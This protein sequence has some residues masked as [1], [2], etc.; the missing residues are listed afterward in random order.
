[1]DTDS[2][3]RSVESTQR[4]LNTQ[5][6]DEGHGVRIKQYSKKGGMVFGV[7]GSN[8]GE[9]DGGSTLTNSS[10]I[11]SPGSSEQG[12]PARD[13]RRPR[14][15]SEPRRSRG[16][17][18]Y[19]PGGLDGRSRVE[20]RNRSGG[21]GRK[22]RDDTGPREK[23]SSP[24]SDYGSLVSD[25]ENGDALVLKTAWESTLHKARDSLLQTSGNPRESL[26]V[27]T[28]TNRRQRQRSA[29]ESIS[30]RLSDAQ[31]Q[32]DKDLE[33]LW[34][35]SNS[36]DR[37]TSQYGNNAV[38]VRG[39]RLQQ[40]GAFNIGCQINTAESQNVPVEPATGMNSSK[41]SL[42]F[43]D[44]IAIAKTGSKVNDKN[45]LRNKLAIGATGV[46][47]EDSGC[48]GCERERR[49]AM[50]STHP[51]PS[52]S[53]SVLPPASRTE[54]SHHH[55]QKH[56]NNTSHAAQAPQSKPQ[57]KQPKQLLPKSASFVLPHRPSLTLS[58]PPG[59]SSLQP[60]RS[61]SPC[62]TD[63]RVK[64]LQENNSST[65]RSPANP[66]QHQ[67]HLGK[68]TLQLNSSSS[69]EAL[70]RADNNSSASH[71]KPTACTITKGLAQSHLQFKNN[72]NSK[73]QEFLSLLSSASSVTSSGCHGDGSVAGWSGG[74]GGCH[75]G[76]SCCL[77]VVQDVLSRIPPVVPSL[78]AG[79]R[80][81]SVLDLSWCSRS[82]SA[83]GSL[84]S[85]SAEY[86]PLLCG[87]AARYAAAT[88]APS[89]QLHPHYATMRLK[90]S[91]TLMGNAPC[92]KQRHQRDVDNN[93]NNAIKAKHVSCLLHFSPTAFL[94]T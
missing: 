37:N 70:T 48:R 94:T 44:K 66:A 24:S 20:P 56:N 50:N 49:Q 41:D 72:N 33:D 19:N 91:A 76:S 11:S 83:G 79:S 64:L 18:R 35:E 51:N 77:N 7:Y 27:E 2:A 93:V 10:G 43:T 46:K 53:P 21:P 39:A 1:M 55:H 23:E 90:R 29:S 60:C 58:R 74:G 38:A 69:S 47:G 17:P 61:Q 8:P 73:S 54:R 4:S 9:G 65:G 3:E 89:R 52:P 34:P 32:R 84:G 28:P 14:A 36:L 87:N 40:T 78:G 45:G 85:G 59:P 15:R 30:D 92:W 22:P 75:G 31:A 71:L 5:R 80:I 82:S 16:E 68:T 12:S 25:T 62:C 86:P 67:H 13:K 57:S 63:R 88:A 26:N 42:R 6:S 81:S